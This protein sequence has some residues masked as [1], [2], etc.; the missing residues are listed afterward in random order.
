MLL[1]ALQSGATSKTFLSDA[2]KAWG[3]IAA[4]SEGECN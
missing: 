4:G 2:A 1:P 3:G